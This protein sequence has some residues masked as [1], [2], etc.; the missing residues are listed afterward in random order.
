MSFP[1]I[2]GGAGVPPGPDWTQ[3]YS[4]E[5]DIAAAQTEW[6]VVIRELQNPSICPM[7]A[8][9]GYSVTLPY[10]LLRAA[11]P[12][13]SVCDLLPSGSSVIWL[14]FSNGANYTNPKPFLR[15]TLKSVVVAV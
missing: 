14:H 3:L 12:K 6:G 8:D 13:G 5:L 4:D 2:G 10:P 11:D 7:G 15:L 9:V 1:T